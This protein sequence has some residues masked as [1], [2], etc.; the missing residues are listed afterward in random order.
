MKR[1]IGVSGI[2]SWSDQKMVEKKVRTSGLDT[3][4]ETQ[5]VSGVQVTN[6]TLSGTENKYGRK[7]YPV[8]DE[9]QQAGY[10]GGSLQVFLHLFEEKF[11]DIQDTI[12]RVGRMTHQFRSGWQLNMTPF[13]QVSVVDVFARLRSEFPRDT[14]VLQCHALAMNVLGPDGVAEYVNALKPDYALLDASHGRGLE[15]YTGALKNFVKE[16]STIRNVGI[17]VAGG[18]EADNL[19]RLL[20][21]LLE[22]NSA[23]GWDAEGKLRSEGNDGKKVLDIEKVHQY[24]EESS[25]ILKQLV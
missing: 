24:L 4:F 19:E 18:L 22:I 6:K 15:L 9:I 1:I 7:W 25:R 5:V 16:M 12:Q 10:R 17:I 23:I 11:E 13:H 3:C 8:G 21:P 14:I 20:G 2:A